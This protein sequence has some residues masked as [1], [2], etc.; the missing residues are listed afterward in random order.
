MVVLRGRS[1][2]YLP[3][4]TRLVSLIA[5]TGI[6]RAVLLLSAGRAPDNAVRGRRARP[7]ATAATMVYMLLK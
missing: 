4:M 6:M 1:A 2:K 5:R 7:D 3:P